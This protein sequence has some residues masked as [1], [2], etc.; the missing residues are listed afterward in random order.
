MG[1][2]VMGDFTDVA[3]TSD[4]KTMLKNLLVWKA[5]DIDVD[6]EG[7]AFHPGSGL[8]LNHI[9]GHQDGCATACPGD[10][11]YPQLP[12]IRIQVTDQIE[13][14]CESELLAA[15]TNLEAEVLSTSSIKLNWTDNSN[16]E[17]TFIVERSIMTNSNFEIIGTTNSNETTYTDVS[18]QANTAYFYQVKAANA[19]DTTLYTNQIGVATVLTST[20]NVDELSIV[21]YP[22]PVIDL[23]SIVFPEGN[24]SSYDINVF[25]I[26]TSKHV[27]SYTAKNEST[28]IITKY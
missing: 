8:N 27:K 18:L 3:P 28:E 26:A 22:N 9:S 11:F 13:N 7:S 21:A 2:C 20:K 23:L 5:C 12:T 4:A 6:P 1:V 25:E 15:P 16:N 14:N 24:G 10:S 17:N 19:Q